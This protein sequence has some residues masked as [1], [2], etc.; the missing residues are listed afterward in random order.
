MDALLFA[1]ASWAE[2]FTTSTSA[3]PH[4][5][6]CQSQLSQQGNSD[7]STIDFHLPWMRADGTVG[8]MGSEVPALLKVVQ[9]LRRQRADK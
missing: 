1:F 2:L 3:F 6:W 4:V 8:N 9:W 5:K 7:G